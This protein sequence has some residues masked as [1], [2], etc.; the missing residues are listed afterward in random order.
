MSGHAA[1]V[2]AA[3]GSQ[4]LGAAKQRL[5][6][7][8]EPLLRRSVRLAL[9][10]EPRRC[11]VVL[12]GDATGMQELLGGMPVQVVVNAQWRKGMGG[13]LACLREAVEGDAAVVRSLILGCDQP[14]L[15]ASHLNT[16][17]Q[18]AGQSASGCAVSGYDGIRGIPAVIP[19]ALWLGLP[20]SGDHGLRRLFATL[21]VDT[22]GCVV[23]PALGLDVDTPAD[24][25]RATERGWLD[26]PS[27]GS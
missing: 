23:A 4:R 15:E 5:S 24:V 26:P 11:V 16:L 2:L 21:G 13:S 27:R 22:L 14:A 20:L 8:G 19:Q 25:A 12:G 10:T 6:R 17:L 1:L 9:E 7:D 18:L 3:G